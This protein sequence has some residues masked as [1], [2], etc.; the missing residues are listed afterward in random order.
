[1]EMEEEGEGEEQQMQEQVRGGEERGASKA[2]TMRQR[3]A[4]A[5]SVLK[6]VRQKLDG[7]DKQNDGN[8][9]LTVQEQASDMRQIVK[10]VKSEMAG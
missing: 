7:R 4:H 2:L 9:K 3:N 10:V 1:M 6:R 5:V 8:T